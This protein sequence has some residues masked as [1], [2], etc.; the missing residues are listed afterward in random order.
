MKHQVRVFD[1]DEKKYFWSLEAVLA[2]TKT[3]GRTQDMSQNLLL[4]S[5]LCAMCTLLR[6]SNWVLRNGIV[7]HSC[8]GVQSNDGQKVAVRP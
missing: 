3:H 5:L 2:A 4:M 1:F 7:V 6:A 8:R